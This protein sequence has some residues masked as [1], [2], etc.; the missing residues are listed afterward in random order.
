[1]FL[2]VISAIDG[3][4][5]VGTFLLFDGKF[6]VVLLESSLVGKESGTLL[7]LVLSSFY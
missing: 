3:F 7:A 1:M 5:T 2:Q 6:A 4:A